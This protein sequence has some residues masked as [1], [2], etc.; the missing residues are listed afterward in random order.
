M[1]S[2]EPHG[3]LR[4]APYNVSPRGAERYRVD[5]RDHPR[6][7][8]SAQSVRSPLNY[9]HEDTLALARR[10]ENSRS[11]HARAD[12]DLGGGIGSLAA[13]LND[14]H[15]ALELELQLELEREVERERQRE[16]EKGRLHR[17]EYLNQLFSGYDDDGHS[18]RFD[19][20]VPQPLKIA[21]R[22]SHHGISHD[23]DYSHERSDYLRPDIRQRASKSPRHPQKNEYSYSEHSGRHGERD[24]RYTSDRKPRAR[25][26][27]RS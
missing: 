6:I 15:H 17:L 19:D 13:R 25:S 20:P 18:R 4:G 10:R 26:R 8:S 21:R 14:R 22:R 5:P 9:T 24:E 3:Q 23:H 16:R 12:I 1:G 2:G 11:R 7:Y 27:G